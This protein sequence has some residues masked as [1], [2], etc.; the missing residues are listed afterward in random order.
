MQTEQQTVHMVE[1][2]DKGHALWLLH[3]VEQNKI[4]PRCSFFVGDTKQYVIDYCRKIISSKT[5]TSRVTYKQ[6]NGQGRYHALG[7]NLQKLPRDARH[8]LCKDAYYDIDIVNSQPTI[9]Y[10]YLTKNNIFCPSLQK[11][12]EQRTS[13]LNE[14]MDNFKISKDDAK[15]IFIKML[16]GGGKP[17]DISDSFITSFHKEIKNISNL[18]VNL[19]ENEELV[20]HA[21]DEDKTNVNGCVMCM[22]YQIIE[23]EILQCAVKFFTAHNFHVDVLVFDGFMIRKTKEITDDIIDELNDHV[24]N[25]TGY[26]VQFIIKPMNEGYDIPAEELN[27][28]NNKN[29]QTDDKDNGSDGETPEPSTKT[30]KHDDNLDILKKLTNGQ[31][32]HAELFYEFHKEN[33]IVSQKL[34]TVYFYDDNI[35]LWAPMDNEQ[36]INLIPPFLQEKICDEI[37]KNNIKK[38]II[39]IRERDEQIKLNAELNALLKQA[40]STKHSEQVFK[41]A[42]TKFYNDTL[43]D[44]L[45]LNEFYLPIL[46]KQVVDLRTGKTRERTKY[47][48]FTFECPV[49]LLDDQDTL[50]HAYEFFRQVMNNNEENLLFFQKVLGYICSAWT[51]ERKLFF[52]WGHG[53]NGKS[54]VI[55]ILKLIFG[56]YYT[57]LPKDMFIKNKHSNYKGL[58]EIDMKF[59]HVGVFSESEEGDKLN[60]GLLKAI[61]GGDTRCVRLLFTHKKENYNLIFKPILLTNHKPE[62]NVNDQAMIDRVCFVPF[63]VRF[64]NE[65]R[66]GEFLKD[67][68]KIQLL[69]EKYLNEVFTFIVRGAVLYHTK[70]N[71][72]PPQNIQNATNEY[73]NEFDTVNNFIQEKCIANYKEKI[74]TSV[75]YENYKSYCIENAH[76]P[77]NNKEFVNIMKSKFETSTYLGYQYYKGVNV[78]QENFL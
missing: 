21:Q 64:T 24:Y 51:I 56:D 77:K 57:S 45:N 7:A 66:N 62:I 53:S 28:I 2:I 59:A 41:Q 5:E 46:N 54:T 73:I 47:D 58:E 35:A 36:I 55:D 17:K 1:K 43:I 61:T 10:Q 11:Y 34:K 15:M 48:L 78:T 63:N 22:R 32:G 16:N 76:Q 20:K 18:L 12:F 40:T 37:V 49:N 39:D 9:L 29:E 67:P 3:K 26:D 42:R 50:E 52:F 27:P 14:F 74:K 65:P 8:T 13:I 30:D 38:K 71:L 23:N 44:K 25:R 4:T 19:K 70:Q 6:K 31:L 69:K 33:I 68:N 72:K 60:A 75:M